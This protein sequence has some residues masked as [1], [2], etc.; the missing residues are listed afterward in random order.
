M[1]AAALY[2]FLHHTRLG[3]A[4]RA[5]ADNREAAELVGIPTTRVL[6]L[7]FGLG[8]ALWPACRAC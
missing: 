3:K 1:I 2:L 5:V 7:A 4:M 8:V 6:A